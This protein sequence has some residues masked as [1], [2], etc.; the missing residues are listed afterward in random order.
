MKS[1][2][3]E[4]AWVNGD[5]IMEKDV[6]KIVIKDS[7]LQKEESEEMKGKYPMP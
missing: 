3:V 5:I 1:K 6:D 2:D 7:D 4:L